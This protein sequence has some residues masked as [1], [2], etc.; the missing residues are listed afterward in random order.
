MYSLNINYFPTETNKWREESEIESKNR[1]I[2]ELEN[3]V[4]ELDIDN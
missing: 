2:I 3:Y 1:K 4:T